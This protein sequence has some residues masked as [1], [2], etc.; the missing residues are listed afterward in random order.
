MGCNLSICGVANRRLEGRDIDQE[1]RKL[2]TI[3]ALLLERVLAP[4]SIVV[5][6]FSQQL[7]ENVHIT[8]VHNANCFTF[9]N[10][11][12]VAL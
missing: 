3:L 5:T 12:D 1:Q 11:R 10:S 9:S 4:K 8:L 2:S 7:V 6:T